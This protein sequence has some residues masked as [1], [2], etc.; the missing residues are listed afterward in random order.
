MF[1]APSGKT[2]VSVQKEMFLGLGGWENRIKP[3]I[4]NHYGECWKDQVGGWA[5]WVLVALAWNIDYP[6]DLPVL[7]SSTPH[8]LSSISLFLLLHNCG[9]CQ[10]F[11]LYVSRT[12]KCWEIQEKNILVDGEW[13]GGTMPVCFIHSIGSLQIFFLAETWNQRSH[14]LD[15]MNYSAVWHKFHNTVCFRFETK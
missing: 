11:R 13:G 15:L 6:T 14:V 2:H 5:S 10:C 8:K 7:P 12:G 1:S 4:N 3:R 9:H